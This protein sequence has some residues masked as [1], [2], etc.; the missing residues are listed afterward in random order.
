M[1]TADI[2]IGS[3]LYLSKKLMLACKH[4][5]QALC[6][7]VYFVDSAYCKVASASHTLFHCTRCD[8][9]DGTCSACI[10]L[11]HALHSDAIPRLGTL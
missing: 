11:R 10:K 9:V 7:G 6:R 2:R 4:A 8:D 1:K 5:V 3:V